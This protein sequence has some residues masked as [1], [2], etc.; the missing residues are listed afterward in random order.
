MSSWHF[1]STLFTLAPDIQVVTWQ[2]SALVLF[3]AVTLLFSNPLKTILLI[4]F[5]HLDTVLI[6]QETVMM[7]WLSSQVPLWNQIIAWQIPE[8]RR[9]WKSLQSHKTRPTSLT[10]GQILLSCSDSSKWKQMQRLMPGRA[11]Y[12]GY[13]G[14]L[15]LFSCWDWNGAKLTGLRCVVQ[16]LQSLLVFPLNHLDEEADKAGPRLSAM[17]VPLCVCLGVQISP[18]HC[19]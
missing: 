7:N 1:Q 16:Q 5:S 6:S 18:G 19:H 17:L 3:P 13:D 15:L 4:Q 2:W 10:N 11:C 8:V 12:P 14:V 9:L